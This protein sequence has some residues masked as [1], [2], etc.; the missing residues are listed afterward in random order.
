M[1]SIF[2]FFFGQDLQDEWPWLNTLRC[3]SKFNGVE[4]FFACGEIPWAEGPS[5][6]NERPR[7]QRC[8]CAKRWAESLGDVRLPGRSDL[9]NEK[10]FGIFLTLYDAERF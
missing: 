1:D 6:L 2:N 4:I 8:L 5:R 9:A 7:L 3:S 10:L